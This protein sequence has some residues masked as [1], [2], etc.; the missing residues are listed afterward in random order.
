MMPGQ[1][2]VVEGLEGAGKTTAIETIRHYLQDRVKKVIV[3]REP[4]GTC[5]GEKLRA[6]I[7]ESIPN[8][9]L[10]SLSE[11]LMIYAARVQLIQNVIRPALARGDWILADRFELS[12][13][14]YQG[15][16]RGIHQAILDNLSSF[17]LSGLKPDLTIFLDITPEQGLQRINNRGKIDRIEQEPLAFFNRVYQAYHQKLEQIESAVV[18]DA[19]MPVEKVQ[20]SICLQLKIFLDENAYS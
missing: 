19:S 2:I 8:E 12:T 11:L 14:A 16:G 1:F 3:T 7:K 10:D 17:C 6:L 9:P 20:Q 4:G 15:G 13:Y 5:I 18:I